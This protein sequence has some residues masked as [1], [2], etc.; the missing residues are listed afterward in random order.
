MRMAE[1]ASAPLRLCGQWSLFDHTTIN[2]PSSS[3]HVMSK[4][5]FRRFRFFPV[6]LASTTQLF[7]YRIRRTNLRRIIVETQEVPR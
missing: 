7:P 6:A 3:A 1:E 4:Y 5:L 2:N